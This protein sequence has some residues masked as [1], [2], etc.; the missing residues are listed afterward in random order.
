MTPNA[1]AKDNGE[2]GEAT[3]QHILTKKFNN[4]QYVNGLIDYYAGAGIPIEVKT[5]QEFI[6]RGEASKYDI[7]HGRFTLEKDQ[8]DFL[9]HKSGYY[10]F[11]VKNGSL[12]VRH[13]LIP[14]SD[15][16]FMKQVTWRRIFIDS[17]GVIG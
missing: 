17:Q 6:E 3:A 14:A 8:H 13:L 9:L 10:L 7:R 1:K 16:G 15:I 2:W 4:V 5:C 12:L 11:L